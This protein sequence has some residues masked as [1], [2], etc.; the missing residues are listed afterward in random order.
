[1]KLQADFVRAANK[2][3]STADAINTEIYVPKMSS[4]YK[5]ELMSVPEFNYILGTRR[6]GAATSA[7][8]LYARAR[9]IHACRFALG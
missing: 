8:A 2:S 9:S 7:D 6:F 3:H 5:H 4:T 1:M